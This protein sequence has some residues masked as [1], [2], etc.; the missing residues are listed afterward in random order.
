[1]L[2]PQEHL[3]AAGRDWQLLSNGFQQFHLLL[4]IAVLLLLLLLLLG[5][6]LLVQLPQPV[7]RYRHAGARPTTSS[8]S[9]APPPAPGSSA[10]PLII[11]AAVTAAAAAAVIAAWRVRR[12][13]VVL[14]QQ[15]L[16]LWGRKQEGTMESVHTLL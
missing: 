14:D 5:A 4:L 6:V 16:D 11:A 1:M 13:D 2:Q 15:L 10:A 8:S 9:S 7:S 12:V 3:T